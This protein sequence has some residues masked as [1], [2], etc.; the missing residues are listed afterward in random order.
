MTRLTT[1]S[2]I[3]NRRPGLWIVAAGGRLFT[4]EIGLDR[5]TFEFFYRVSF[6]ARNAQFGQVES[7]FDFCLR[8]AGV[9]SSGAA[10]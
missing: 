7:A 3:E 2:L 1:N 4:V 10:R 6:G 8:Y 5:T 9:T